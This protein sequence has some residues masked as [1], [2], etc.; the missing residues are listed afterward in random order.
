MIRNPWHVRIALGLAVALVAS[1]S[2]LGAVKAG[3]D[4]EAPPAADEMVCEPQAAISHALL[5]SLAGSWT[6]S[7]TSMH[8]DGTGKSTFTLGVGGT[9][10]VQDYEN[11]GTGPDG[12]P[13]SFYGHGVYKVSEDG[14][15]LTGWWFDSMSKEPNVLTGPLTETG[16]ELTGDM[17]GMG[18]FT[19]RLAK[20]DAGL[21]FKMF[22]GEQT[23]MTETYTRSPSTSVR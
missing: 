11:T 22:S 3:D 16:Y 15:T 19:V 6:T 10:L 1:V 2:L 17:P 21:E 12:A 4:V 13:M 18:P 23:F 14:K 5:K 7:S 8:G 9:A 20:T